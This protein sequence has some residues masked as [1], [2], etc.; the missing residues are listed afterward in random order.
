MACE[1]TC[2]IT[3]SAG[4]FVIILILL[5]AC[6]VTCWIH[7]KKVARHRR[8]MLLRALLERTN[9]STSVASSRRS[10]FALGTR[11]YQAVAMPLDPYTP[12]PTPPPTESSNGV[13]WRELYKVI[14]LFLYT[15][16]AWKLV[17]KIHMIISQCSKLFTTQLNESYSC[18]FLMQSSRVC[19]KTFIIV[20]QYVVR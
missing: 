19:L 20:L 3:L 7:R 8:M 12:P 6:V 16:S 14:S 11:G 9:G 13:T 1:E 17:L 18:I 2:Y 4:A 15:I 5:L 10:S